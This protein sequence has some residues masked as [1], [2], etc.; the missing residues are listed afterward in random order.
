MLFFVQICNNRN[1]EKGGFQKEGSGEI[2]ER[3]DDEFFVDPALYDETITDRVVTLDERLTD[4][5]VFD[6]MKMIFKSPNY[7]QGCAFAKKHS[8]VA[9]L[10][11]SPPYEGGTV[12]VRKL[13]FPET[14]PDVAATMRAEYQSGMIQE[15]EPNGQGWGLAPEFNLAEL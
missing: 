8:G 2:I 7:F 14:P 4:E 10:F 9:K 15:V 6:I 1:K 13:G 11:F 12:A 5:A 3:R